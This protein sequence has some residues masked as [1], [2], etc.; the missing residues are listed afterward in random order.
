MKTKGNNFVRG[1]SL[2]DERKYTLWKI[3]C[4]YLINIKNLKYEQAYEILNIWL[5]KC[6]ILRNL[7]F[8]IYTKIK[9]NIGC[10]KHYNPISIKTFINDNKDLYLQLQPKI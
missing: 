10:V 3:L 7:N 4:P 2:E 5:E 1:Y 8:D 6:N 9:D